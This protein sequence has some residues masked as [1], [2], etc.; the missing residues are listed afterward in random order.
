MLLT[1]FT[2]KAAMVLSCSLWITLQDGSCGLSAS[3]VSAPP[4]PPPA[5]GVVTPPYTTHN[6]MTSHMTTTATHTHLVHKDVIDDGLPGLILVHQIL[7]QP[8]GFPGDSVPPSEGGVLW[9]Q[10]ELVPHEGEAHPELG[11]LHVL[12]RAKEVVWWLPQCLQPL[13]EDRLPLIKHFEGGIEERRHCHQLCR[14]AGER[15]VTLKI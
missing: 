15:E 13:G 12:S 2:Q 14:G 8:L 10:D 3:S 4:P 1:E 7:P 11:R 5:M 6:H 9:L